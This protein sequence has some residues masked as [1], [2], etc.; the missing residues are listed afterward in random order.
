[1]LLP[2]WVQIREQSQNLFLIGV[3][4]V[5]NPANICQIER[6]SSPVTAIAELLPIQLTLLS[7]HE[8]QPI[9]GSQYAEARSNSDDRASKPTKIIGMP[10]HTFPNANHCMKTSKYLSVIMSISA[11]WILLDVKSPAQGFKLELPVTKSSFVKF[12]P[13]QVGIFPQ[14]YRRANLILAQNLDS[15]SITTDINKD[16]RLQDITIT[17]NSADKSLLTV[18]GFINNRSEQAHYVYYIVAKFIAND[19]AIKQTIIPVNIDIEPGQSQ[20]F[21]HEVSTNS[22]KSIAPQTV[23]PLVVKYEYR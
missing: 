1:M 5:P 10:R 18:K 12:A 11:V 9:G 7:Q 15:T 19:T 21:T 22:I 4:A 8:V 13:Q 16:L 20:P 23:K 17:Q 2:R 14:Q 6:G 3:A